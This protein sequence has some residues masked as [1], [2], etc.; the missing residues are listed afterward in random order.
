MLTSTFSTAG[1]LFS[2][3]R[4]LVFLAQLLTWDVLSLKGF[5]GQARL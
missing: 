1:L 2:Q 5:Y 4:A 3:I